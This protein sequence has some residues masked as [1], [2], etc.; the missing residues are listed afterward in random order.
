[1]PLLCFATLLRKEQTLVLLQVVVAKQGSDDHIV[2]V[3]QPPSLLY[4][5]TA[6]HHAA[7]QPNLAPGGKPRTVATAELLLAGM[8]LASALMQLRQH[9]QCALEQ[10][11]K[12]QVDDS[13][14]GTIASILLVGKC[15]LGVVAASPYT[16]TPGSHISN[17]QGLLQSRDGSSFLH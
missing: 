5:T 11:A 15:L 2:A 9:R 7:S 16:S 6:C 13:A 17:S 10:T 4:L 1:V 8:Y 14:A 12:E 3:Q